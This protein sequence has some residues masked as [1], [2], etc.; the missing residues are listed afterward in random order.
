MLDTE[1]PCQSGQKYVDCCDPYLAA[2]TTPPTAEALMRARYTAHHQYN[3]E[4]VK[5]TIH[6]D[7]RAQYFEWEVAEWGERAKWTGLTIEETE[8]GGSD[9]SEGVVQF[10]AEYELDGDSHRLHERS[11]FAKHDGLWYYTHGVVPQASSKKVGRNE[12]CPCGS[13]KKYKKCCGK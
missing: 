4:F 1:C 9:D 12:P 5:A 8:G 7:A 11:F 2:K 10:V 13:G 6:P 3:F